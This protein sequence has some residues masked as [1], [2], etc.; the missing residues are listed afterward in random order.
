MALCLIILTAACSNK[1]TPTRSV[2]D[3]PANRKAAAQRYLEAMPSQ[4]MLHNV[5]LNMTS[6][7]PPKARQRFLKAQNDK[8]LL[9]KTYNI[10]EKALVKYF[11]PDELNAMTNFYGSPAGKSARPKFSPYMMTIM[12]R[13][14]REVRNMIVKMQL[15]EQKGQPQKGAPPAAKPQAKPVPPEPAKPVKPHTPQPPGK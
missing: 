4:Q 13:I 12:P 10:S 7:L 9:K 3:T 8:D 11:T 1:S 6:K 15:P 14:T 2:P 5:I